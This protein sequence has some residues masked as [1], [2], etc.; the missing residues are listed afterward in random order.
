MSKRDLRC[1]AFYGRSHGSVYCATGCGAEIRVERTTVM[2]QYA[3]NRGRWF[4]IYGRDKT[5]SSLTS[6]HFKFTRL[7]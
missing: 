4:N 6:S 5:R 3:A 1:K 7:V 2:L